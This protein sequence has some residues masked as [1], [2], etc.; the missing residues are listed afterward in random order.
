MDI[1][2]KKQRSF[3]MSQI[4]SRNTKPEL[5]LRK[6]LYASGIK[7]YRLSYDLYGKPDLWAVFE[8]KSLSRT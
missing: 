6:I 1:K 8:A 5:I 2:S 7:G 4:K 3:N